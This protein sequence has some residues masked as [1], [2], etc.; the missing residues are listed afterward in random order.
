MLRCFIA[1]ALCASAA[2]GARADTISITPTSM[3][4]V[5]NRGDGGR[6]EAGNNTI[7]GPTALHCAGAAG[8]LVVMQATI[9]ITV[10]DAQWN[11]CAFLDGARVATDCAIQGAG[12]PLEANTGNTMQSVLISQGDHVMKTKVHVHPLGSGQVL[13]H[14]KP[15]EIHYTVY[16]Q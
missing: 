9:G 12:I 8:C 4:I 14:L 16:E 1:L 10:S 2:A 6:L 15:W 3:S 7:D 13:P 11:I 5:I